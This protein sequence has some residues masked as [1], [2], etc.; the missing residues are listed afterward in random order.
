VPAPQPKSLL[1]FKQA[2]LLFALYFATARFGLSLDAVGGFATLVWPPAGIALAALVLY[3]LRLWPAVALA[4]FLINLL[5]GAPVLAALGISAGNSLEALVGAYFLRRAGFHPQLNRLKDAFK[6]LV[7]AAFC[8]PWFSALIG[9]TSLWS[10]GKID[11]SQFGATLD[12]WWLGDTVGILVVAPFLLVAGSSPA[13]SPGI[14][15]IAEIAALALASVLICTSVF[16]GLPFPRL[17][18]LHDVYFVFPIMLWAT[19]RFSQYGAV[20]SALVI[21]SL[22]VWGTALGGGPF[23]GL[24]L[25]QGLAELQTFMSVF[26]IT[27]IILGSALGERILAEK[28]MSEALAQRDEFLS[29]ASHELRTPVTSLMLQLQL[30]QS[31]AKETSHQGAFNERL[32]T[33]LRNFEKAIIQLST[34]LD[35]LLDVTRIRGGKLKLYRENLDLSATV[36]EVVDRFSEDSL[37]A[38]TEIGLDIDD[39]IKGSWDRLRIEQVITNLISNAL[40]YG[41]AKPVTVKLRIEPARGVTVLQVIDQGIGMRPEMQHRL[42]RRFERA[43]VHT[44]ISG[45]GLGLYISNQIVQA[46]GGV[47]N[48]KSEFGQGSEFRI[49]LPL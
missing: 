23:A 28:G 25:N 2:A 46:H 42:F 14:K 45:L 24:P 40:K 5:A 38:N 15:R 37:K 47:I 34:L 20:T 18:G 48:V 9:V 4:A 39:A 44:H 13:K 3:G 6:F 32:H 36:R 10:V 16:P 22:S 1:A 21:T 41:E 43:P 12:A 26:A 29:V 30:I 49:E 11:G 35:T 7:I 8:S 17:L 31:K 19:L 27:S 33:T